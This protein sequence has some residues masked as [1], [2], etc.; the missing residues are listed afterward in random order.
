[1]LQLDDEDQFGNTTIVSQSTC[2]KN[3][4][5]VFCTNLLVN[6]QVTLHW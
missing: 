3:E 5:V 4:I 6:E 1:M 2:L